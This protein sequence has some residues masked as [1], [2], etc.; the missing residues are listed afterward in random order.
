MKA[1]LLIILTLYQFSSLA[2]KD[3]TY[4]NHLIVKLA[5]FTYLGTHAAIQVGFETNITQK[6][7]IG[8]D[9]AYGNANMASYQKGG[10][11]V[12]G[13]SSNRYRFD[14]RW[15][16]KIFT[17]TRYNRNQFW[18]VELYNRTNYYP[19][20]TTIGRNCSYNNNG[21]RNSCSYYEK[22]SDDTIAQ[23]WGIF[24]KY[25]QV[26]QI[27]NRFSIEWYGG[28]GLSSRTNTI[29]KYSLGANDIVFGDNNGDNSYFNFHKSSNFSRKGGDILLTIKFNYR[30]F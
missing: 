6:M 7:T 20:I 15:Y 4:Q 22:L 26:R 13:E 27:D 23:V 11:Y 10:S 21:F 12:D 18:G 8:F 1:K 19:S 24:F 28:L 2:Q 30:I 16:E 5:P 29:G 3:S 17:Q 25:G 14:F 9:Y